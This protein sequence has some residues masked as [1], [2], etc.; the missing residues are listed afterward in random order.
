MNLWVPSSRIRGEG[1]SSG[2]TKRTEEDE[3]DRA[4]TGVPRDAA[5]V[6]YW[7]CC[8]FPVGSKV[9]REKEYRPPM[10]VCCSD[11]LNRGKKKVDIVSST[12]NLDIIPFIVVGL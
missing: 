12:N 4:I 1:S 5:R 7:T 6:A 8:S 2:L 10:F 9:V 11:K 3:R